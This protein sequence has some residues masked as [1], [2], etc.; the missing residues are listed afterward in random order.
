[1]KTKRLQEIENYIFSKGTVTIDELCSTFNVSKNTIRRDINSIVEK[2]E[3]EKVY[4][5]VTVAE[6]GLIPYEERNTSNSIGKVSISECAA[7]FIEDDDIVFI[8]SGTTTRHIV[9]FIPS[10]RRLTIVTNNLDVINGAA[11]LS[12]IKII[13]IG[14]IYRRKTNSFIGMDA[15]GAFEQ[16]NIDKAFMS[17][18]GISLA[19]GLTNSDYPEFPIKQKAVE[20]ANTLYALVDSSKFDKYTLMTYAPFERINVL[21]TDHQLESKYDEFCQEHG[22]EIH[23]AGRK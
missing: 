20:K 7:Q 13:L 5:G 19:R 14:N 10:T 9:K 4:G 15:F 23:L 11:P 8:D 21:I 18:T 17:A 2:G 16:F 1:M 12:N 3:F 6:P 22:I